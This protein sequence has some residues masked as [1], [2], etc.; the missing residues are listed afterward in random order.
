MPS[1]DRNDGVDAEERTDRG[2]V[3]AAGMSRGSKEMP[4]RVSEMSSTTSRYR[5]RLDKCIES[6]RLRSRFAVGL[7]IISFLGSRLP[8]GW[9]AGMT[10]C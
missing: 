3:A 1:R 4:M 10:G 2:S 6:R 9:E 7:L 8:G 5:C